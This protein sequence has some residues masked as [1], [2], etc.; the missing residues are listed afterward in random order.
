MVRGRQP[1][2]SGWIEVASSAARIRQESCISDV[3]PHRTEITTGG[4]ERWSNPGHLTAG[5]CNRAASGRSKDVAMLLVV[6][7]GSPARP[8]WGP[9]LQMRLHAPSGLDRSSSGASVCA[10]VISS[11]PLPAR[12]MPRSVVWA[13]QTQPVVRSVKRTENEDGSQPARTR[14]VST[15]LL[16]HGHRPKDVDTSQSWIWR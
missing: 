10:R 6:L 1:F 2:W 8:D 13:L 11:G 7:T 15:K 14:R 16:R 12:H 9:I 4:V 5:R 3:I